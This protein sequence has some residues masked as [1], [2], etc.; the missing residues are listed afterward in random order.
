MKV[1][2]LKGD[3]PRHNYFAK[4]IFEIEG[5]ECKII[6]H[7]R[8]GNYRL[9]KMLMK[10]PATFFSRVSKYIFQKLRNWNQREELFFGKFSF[11]KEIKVIDLN[12]KSSVAIMKDFTPDLIVAFG[13]PIISNKVIDIPKYGAINLHGGISPEY[14]GG[15]TIFWPLYKGDLYKTGATLHYMVKKVDSGKIISKIH[16]DL[17]SKDTEFSV[18]VKTFKYAVEEMTNIVKWVKKEERKIPGKIQIGEGN[19][20]LAKHRTFMVEILGAKKIRKK[21]E[22]ISIN[23]KIERFY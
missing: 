17:N 6:S 18:S 16:P 1:L 10:S 12:S 22:N 4:E 15:N 5:I 2:V 7:R 14:K 20:Y 8:L 11:S 3:S 23:K 21:L 13:I 19:L 9:K